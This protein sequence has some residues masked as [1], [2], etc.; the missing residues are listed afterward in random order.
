[1]AWEREKGIGTN[2]AVPLRRFK[3]DNV[4]R[5]SAGLS[6]P[7]SIVPTPYRLCGA[8]RLTLAKIPNPN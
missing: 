4:G 6:M 2:C 3:S 5:A 1:L 7:L 8:L